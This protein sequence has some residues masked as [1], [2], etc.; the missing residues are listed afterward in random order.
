MAAILLKYDA[1]LRRAYAQAILGRWLGQG[2]QGRAASRDAI[3][4]WAQTGMN[5]P[6][7]RVWREARKARVWR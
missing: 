3:R 1:I 2:W 4:R 5:R 7:A 6:R